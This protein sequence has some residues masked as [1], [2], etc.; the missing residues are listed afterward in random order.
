MAAFSSIKR[1]LR[2]IT[3]ICRAGRFELPTFGLITPR[4]AD[5][6]LTNVRS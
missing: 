5:A 3:E 6:V 4:A 1:F 2:K